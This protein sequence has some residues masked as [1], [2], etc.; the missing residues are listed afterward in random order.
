[1]AF[2]SATPLAGGICVLGLVAVD[3]KAGHRPCYMG[4]PN[5]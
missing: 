2:D 5:G 3:A 4:T 1:M